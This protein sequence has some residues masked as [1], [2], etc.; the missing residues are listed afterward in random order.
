MRPL[1]ASGEVVFAAAKFATLLIAAAIL[2]RHARLDRP[3]VMRAC[4]LASLAYLG[5]LG[6][7]FAYG[8]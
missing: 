4:R 1:L 7:A 2:A 6:A 8:R 3:A 5:L